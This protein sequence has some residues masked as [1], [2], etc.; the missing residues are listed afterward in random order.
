[1]AMN[2]ELINAL[3]NLGLIGTIGGGYKCRVWIQTDGSVHANAYAGPLANALT[4]ILPDRVLLQDKAAPL[5]KLFYGVM[6]EFNPETWTPLRPGDKELG[7]VGRPYFDLVHLIV[8]HEGVKNGALPE[9]SQLEK[10]FIGNGIAVVLTQISSMGSGKEMRAT[11]EFLWPMQFGVT[12]VVNL[13]LQHVDELLYGSIPKDNGRAVLS[14]WGVLPQAKDSDGNAIEPKPYQAEGMM[15]S[16]PRAPKIGTFI[17]PEITPN[18]LGYALALIELAAKAGW[19][20]LLIAPDLNKAATAA[21]NSLIVD[22]ELAVDID[23]VTKVESQLDIVGHLATCD[24]TVWL[25]DGE[26]AFGQD[27]RVAVGAAARVP[28]V[29]MP[30]ARTE[31]YREDAAGAVSFCW[32]DTGAEEIASILYGMDPTT[33][34]GKPAYDVWRKRVVEYAELR[35]WPARAEEVLVAYAKA[36]QITEDRRMRRVLRQK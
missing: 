23:L 35:S 16:V 7:N 28:C 25:P 20:L 31:G 34:D 29:V 18:R 3:T 17:E 2:K 33:N 8:T 30:S 15:T 27:W 19:D 9:A 26:H 11:S 14:G 6:T 36:L 5:A 32:T 24:A 1:M 22:N 10:T 21:I 4:N 13:T 12:T